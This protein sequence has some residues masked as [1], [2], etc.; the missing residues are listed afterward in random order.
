MV[1]IPEKSLRRE[2]D[3]YIA[4]VYAGAP[5]SEAQFGHLH[6][7]FMAGVLIA[8]KR[9]VGPLSHASTAG[10]GV[11]ELRDELQEYWDE[12]LEDK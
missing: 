3:E 6:V 10:I 7:A 1:A 5:M 11:D 12:R 4:R 2:F 9:L 8:F